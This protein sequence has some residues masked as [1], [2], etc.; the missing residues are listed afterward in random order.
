VNAR[1]ATSAYSVKKDRNW[2]LVLLLTGTVFL[3]VAFLFLNFRIASSNT[4]S[5]KSVMTTSLGEGLPD[6]MQRREKINL[7]LVGEG[8]LIAAL[9]NAIVSEMNN[10]GI[11]DVQPVQEI[12]PKYQNPVLVVKVGR[13]GLLWTPFFATSRF[14]M[15]AGYSSTGDTTL[16]GQTPVTTDNRDSLALSMYGE[17]KINDRSWG[18]ISRLGYHQLLADYLA[19]QIVTSLKDLYKVST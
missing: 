16:I 19:Q 17:Y 7:V 11:A 12:L 3:S 14:T 6:A 4:K 2:Q 8:Q 9:R 13:P 5:E 18:L 10:A 15:E 1:F